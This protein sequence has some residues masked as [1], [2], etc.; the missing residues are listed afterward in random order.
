MLP[1]RS[2]AYNKLTT[3][4][5]FRRSL[6]QRVSHSSNSTKNP[7]R[8]CKPPISARG[9]G[10]RILT[11]ALL[12]V[13]EKETGIVF[14]LVRSFWEGTEFRC[15][16]AAP[17]LK[18]LLFI[19]AK[20]VLNHW[21]ESLLFFASNLKVYA[22]ALYVE[23]AK[24]AR[25][26]KLR[27]RGDFFV[28]ADPAAFCDAILDGAFD[29]ILQITM[30]RDVSPDQFIEAIDE[31]LGPKIRFIGASNVFD[32]FKAYFSKQNLSKGELL[33]VLLGTCII[34]LIGWFIQV[35]LFFFIGE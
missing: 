15:L 19:K 5:Y 6:V 23:P 30:A 2:V 3:S 27:D 35:P 34:I 20:V 1:S 17:R 9:I 16:G 32:S 28:D 4:G 21:H 11:C 13:T 31:A 22:I 7:F 8:V 26:L 29:K 24:A 14:P 25:E 12:T 10:S 18:K 33:I